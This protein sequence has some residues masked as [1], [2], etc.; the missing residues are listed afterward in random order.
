MLKDYKRKRWVSSKWAEPGDRSKSPSQDQLRRH[1]T[2]TIWTGERQTHH[3]LVFPSIRGHALQNELDGGAPRNPVARAKLTTTIETSSSSKDGPST[4]SPSRAQEKT[5]G[6]CLSQSTARTWQPWRIAGTHTRPHHPCGP[7]KSL[8]R[9]AMINISPHLV[10][11][12]KTDV[13]AIHSRASVEPRRPFSS[14]W[15]ACFYISCD[16]IC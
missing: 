8:Y 14:P 11:P 13:S 6:N 4:I 10:L 12:D 9:L 5:C 7:K 3:N 15:D 16:K 1:R 2:K